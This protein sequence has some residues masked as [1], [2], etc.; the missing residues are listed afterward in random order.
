[1]ALAALVVAAVIV[2]LTIPRPQRVLLG[3]AVA[4]ALVLAGLPARSAYLDNR[5]RT[6][7]T[8]WPVLDRTAQDTRGARIG[9][10]AFS[11]AYPLFGSDL[12][13]HVELVATVKEADVQPITDCRAWRTA[14]ADGHFDFV[15]TADITSH[16]DGAIPDSRWTADDPAAAIG[17]RDRSAILYRLSGRP[18]P[19]RC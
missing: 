6:G 18:D 10:A 12:S 17:L 1:L 19:D 11:E 14:L 2:L 15:V 9:V 8:E 5:Y 13:N 7:G 16:V 3:A 4:V